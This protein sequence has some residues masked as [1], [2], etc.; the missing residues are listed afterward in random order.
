[1][2]LRLLSS[3]FACSSQIAWVFSDNRGLFTMALDFPPA[4]FMIFNTVTGVKEH[5]DFV[6][7]SFNNLMIA[8]VASSVLNTGFLPVGL[9]H[10]INFP[11]FIIFLTQKTIAWWTLRQST[12]PLTL[13]LAWSIPDISFLFALFDKMQQFYNFTFLHFNF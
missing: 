1:M 10:L 3:F 12:M 5:M 13:D 6:V 9:A 11:S 2:C 7:S 8:L 4:P